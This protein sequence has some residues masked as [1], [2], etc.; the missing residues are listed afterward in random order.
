METLREHLDSADPAI[1]IVYSP[2]L[3]KFGAYQVV[4][5]P[6]CVAD[7]HGYEGWECNESLWLVPS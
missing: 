2:D 4:I 5:F 6:A 3:Y 7:S 1:C